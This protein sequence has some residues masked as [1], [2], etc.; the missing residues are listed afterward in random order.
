[1]KVEEVKMA[2]TQMIKI[3]GLSYSPVGVRL[4][5]DNEGLPEKA[6]ILCQH[7][8]CQA[9]MRARHGEHVLLDKEGISCPAAAAA[10]GFR[11]LPEGLKS[12]KALAGF[13]IVSDEEVGKKMFDVMPK[14][15]PGQIHTLHLFPLDK[16]EY[17]PDVVVV[18]DE[19]EKLMWI[20]LAYLH[21]RGGERV[22]SSTSILQAA[23]VDSTII[24]YL[25]N[26]LNFGYGC[27][28]CRDATDIGKNETLLGFPGNMLPEIVK[29]LEFLSKKAIP[30]SRAKHALAS[31][32]KRGS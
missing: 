28:G 1:M 8:Y 3:L 6:K 30:S 20:C 2:G 27:Y 10:F 29:H 17:L 7:R 18:E 5:S 13:G 32:Q 14:L 9:V 15:K 31:L 23:C 11:P 16:A 22:Q 19:V 4:L 25:E 26:R 24:P 12:G 21:A